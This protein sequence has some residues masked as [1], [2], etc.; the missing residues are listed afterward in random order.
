MEEI[1]VSEEYKKGFNQ[2]Y[3]LKQ[4]MPEILDGL[5]VP[6]NVKNSNDYI[7]GMKDGGNQFAI[8]KERGLIK[9]ETEIGKESKDQERDIDI[10]RD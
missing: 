1:E 8:D 2:G 3:T 5:N 4:H 9:S 7:Q 10:D 6:N